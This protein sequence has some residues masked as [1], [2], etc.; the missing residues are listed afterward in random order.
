MLKFN[1]INPNFKGGF[2]AGF[3]AIIQLCIRL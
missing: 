2:M 3:L 1:M